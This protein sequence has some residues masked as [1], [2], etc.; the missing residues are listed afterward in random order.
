MKR[1][2]LIPIVTLCSI[3]CLDAQ[4]TV[5]INLNNE[6][7]TARPEHYSTNIFGGND[8]EFANSEGYINT[9]KDWNPRFIRFHSSKMNSCTS[10]QSWLDCD[11][12]SWD[13]DKIRDVLEEFIPT[14]ANGDSVVITIFEYPEWKRAKGATDKSWIDTE[15]YANWCAEL[16]R[17]V[18][19]ELGFNVKYWEYI[20]EWDNKGYTGEEM[21]AHYDACYD[22]MKEVDPNIVMM[23]PVTS[24]IGSATSFFFSIEKPLDVYS[25]H[26]YGGGDE[27]DVT[28]IYDRSTKLRDGVNRARELCDEHGFDETPVYVG[29]WNIYWSFDAEG[30]QNMRSLVGA[31]FDALSLKEVV[32]NTSDAN[33]LAISVWEEAGG[34]YSKIEG[35]S[36]GFNPGGHVFNLFSDYGVGQVVSTTSSDETQIQGLTVITD[37]TIML[38]L[39]N[40]AVDGGKRVNLNFNG[41]IPGNAPVKKFEITDD[42]LL[43]SELFAE[44]IKSQW[45]NIEENGV[46]IYVI[47]IGEAPLG[48][49]QKSG[50]LKLFPNPV[51]DALFIRSDTLQMNAQYSISDSAG[52]LIRTGVINES[53][54]DLATMSKG[55]YILSIINEGEVFHFKFFKK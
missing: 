11:N 55:T 25:A 17:I 43:E 28:K 32:E 13:K 50:D 36:G 8:L 26:Q 53:K 34:A 52:N 24:W 4:I 22:A 14:I 42:Q 9:L 37:T 39:M 54:I 30:F 40:R 48:F 47:K 46:V 3:V 12:Q 5:D 20:N 2:I 21:G 7:A 49:D 35:S 33:L 23:G 10:S 45:I 18:N 6:I 15:W 51:K 27:T 44:S 31:C 16:V 41:S 19:V 29:E 38:A 1:L